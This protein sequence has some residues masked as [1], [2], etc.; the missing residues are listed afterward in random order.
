MVRLFLLL[1]LGLTLFSWSATA[2]A[3]EVLTIALL[4]SGTVAWEVDTIRHYGLDQEQGFALAVREMAGNAAS[5][6][7]FQGGQADVVVAD[8]LWAARQRAAGRDYVF[9]PFSKAVGGLVV[10]PGSPAQDLTDLAGMTIGIAGGPIDKSWLILQAYAR[11]VLGFD[12]Q[13]ESEQVYGAPPLIFKKAQQQEIQASI[14]YWHFLARLE[15]EGFRPVMSVDTAARALGLDPEVPLLGYVVRG[16]LLRDRPEVVAGLV[17]ASRSAKVLLA[18]EEAAWQRL[19]PAMRAEED[20]VLEKLRSAFL[21]GTPAEGPV[22]PAAAEGLMAVLGKE[23]GAELVG[24]LTRLP[25]GLLY[26]PQD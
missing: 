13:A 8:L 5:K 26:V 4:K 16:E 7:A 22:D 18:A 21:A 15:G 24:G 3:E 9:I 25:D 10:P 14:N 23:G 12:L 11:E 6:V 19:R 1:F 2:K 17:A 20:A